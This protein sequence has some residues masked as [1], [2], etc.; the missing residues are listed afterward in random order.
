MNSGRGF[1]INW[2]IITLM[3]NLGTD[4]P[5]QWHSF[6]ILYY[7]L[8]RVDKFST[9]VKEIWCVSCW[10]IKNYFSAKTEMLRNLI[11]KI[12]LLISPLFSLKF[13]KTHYYC[14]SSISNSMNSPN[15]WSI[16]RIIVRGRSR[17]SCIWWKGWRTLDQLWANGQEA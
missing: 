1:I 11:L 5:W 14:H 12:F 13:I 17:H 10:N 2:S 16:E 6:H 4:R 15:K 7:T 8:V 9:N 3:A